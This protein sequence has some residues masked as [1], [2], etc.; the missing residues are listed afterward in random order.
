MKGST[1]AEKKKVVGKIVGSWYKR[2]DTDGNGI[3][4]YYEFDEFN[5]YLADLGFATY[6]EE[7]ETK[8]LFN[9]IDINGNGELDLEE[10][11]KYF[12]RKVEFSNKTYESL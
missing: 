4:D 11:I 9:S 6:L 7:E 2:M 8:K 5:D 10:I 3:I 12:I 1:Y